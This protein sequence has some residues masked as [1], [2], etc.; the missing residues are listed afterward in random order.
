[1][2]RHADIRGGTHRTRETQALEEEIRMF[3]CRLAQLG[4]D[5]D[6][7]YE[8]ALSRVYDNL[9]EERRNRLAAM[10]AAGL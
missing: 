2:D 9:L 3:E 6:C 5:G 4:P 1:M 7:A 8:R 10:R